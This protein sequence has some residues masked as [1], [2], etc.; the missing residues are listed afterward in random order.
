MSLR[1]VG[2]PRLMVDAASRLFKRLLF[3]HNNGHVGR[4]SVARLHNIQELALS[5]A[6]ILETII[7]LKSNMKQ[8]P[9]SPP[10]ASNELADPSPLPEI[11]ASNTAESVA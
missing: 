7:Y 8:E 10:A 4:K 3:L 5:K 1:L 11:S 6:V 2:T 9:P